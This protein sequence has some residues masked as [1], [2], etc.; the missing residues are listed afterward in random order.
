VKLNGTSPAQDGRGKIKL[1]EL[2]GVA[3]PRVTSI[4]DGIETDTWLDNWK[5]TVGAREAELIRKNAAALGTRVHSLIAGE[6]VQQPTDLE[7][8][9]AQGGLD[10]LYKHVDEVLQYE[11]RMV[12]GELGFGGTVDAIVRMKNGTLAVIDWKTSK[13][14]QPRHNLQTAAYAMLARAAGYDIE[15]R[16][17]VRLWKDDQAGRVSTRKCQNPRDFDAFR[18]AVVIWHWR[19]PGA[20]TFPEL[21]N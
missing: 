14:L 3:V 8:A 10:W 15:E 5:R 4:L 11:L 21:S 1:Y 13:K 20:A 9:C 18:A 19:H 16:Y 12:D 17:V 6:Q 2:G 7:R